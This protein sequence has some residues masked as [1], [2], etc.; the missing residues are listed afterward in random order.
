MKRKNTSVSELA[1]L[2]STITNNLTI[3][4]LESRLEMAF[5]VM[6]LNGGCCKAGGCYEACCKDGG[7]YGHE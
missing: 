5:L 4:E 6:E 3:E 7:T 2:S 1:S